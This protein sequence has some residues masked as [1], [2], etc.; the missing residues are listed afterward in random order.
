MRMTIYI[1]T[2]TY[3]YMCVFPKMALLF[4]LLEEACVKIALNKYTINIGKRHFAGII[5][6]IIV[7]L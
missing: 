3:T 2:Y 5:L 1:Y 4:G 7:S 6:Y